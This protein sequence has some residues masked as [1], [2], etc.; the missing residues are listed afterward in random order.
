[1]PPGRAVTTAAASQVPK[2][3]PRTDVQ[4]DRMRLFSNAALNAGDDHVAWKFDNVKWLL[5]VVTAPWITTYNGI[6]RKT[7]M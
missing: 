3:A 2:T 5:S 7:I 1:M 6:P 4:R